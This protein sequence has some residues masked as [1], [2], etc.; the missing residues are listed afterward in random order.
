MFNNSHIDITINKN[1]FNYEIFKLVLL[2]FIISWLIQSFHDFHEHLFI[3]VFITFQK[4][5]YF[6]L[7]DWTSFVN[8]HDVEHTS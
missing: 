8:I 5:R 2:D 4:F 6:L 7:R 3:L 1:R